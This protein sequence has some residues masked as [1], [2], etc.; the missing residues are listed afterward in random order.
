M[1]KESKL[2]ITLMGNRDDSETGG[3]TVREKKLN[4]III[5]PQKPF[6]MFQRNITFAA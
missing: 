6:L 5:K 2:R 3:V 1:V 4:L